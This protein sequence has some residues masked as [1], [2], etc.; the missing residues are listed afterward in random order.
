MKK[1]ECSKKHVIISGVNDVEEFE[2][3]YAWKEELL[4]YYYIAGVNWAIVM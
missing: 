1:Y 2:A 3:S 4:I